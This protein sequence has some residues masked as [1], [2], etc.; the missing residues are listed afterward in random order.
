MNTPLLKDVKLVV[1][2]MDG[3]LLNPNH[4]VSNQFINQFWALKEKGITVVAASGRQH[5]SIVEKLAAIENEL[6]IIAENGAMT[7]FHGKETVFTPYPKIHLD[8]TLALLKRQKNMHPVLCTNGSAFIAKGQDKFEP[9][10]REFYSTFNVI[11]QLEDCTQ[12]VLKIAIYH[13]ENS[14]KYIYPVV[15]DLA[16]EVKIKISGP[17][18]VDLSHPNANKGF[19]LNV[20]QKYLGV[21]PEQTMVF[22]DYFNDLEMME[23]AHF[24]YAMANAHPKILEIANYKTLSNSKFGVETVLEKLLKQL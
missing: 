3:T 23:Q 21:A 15:Q 17:N 8:K 6:T 2:D 12:E 1:T 7:T 5:N 18:W 10:L 24:S 9:I 19:A 16:N 4:E 22:G 20:L 11:D 14:E 13:F